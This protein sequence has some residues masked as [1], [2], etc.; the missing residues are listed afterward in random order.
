VVMLRH[1][2][3]CVVAIACLKGSRLTLLVPVNGW[4]ST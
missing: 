3:S 2:A 1:Y 4:S